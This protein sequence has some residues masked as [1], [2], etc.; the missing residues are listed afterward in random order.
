MIGQVI[1]LTG[2]INENSSFLCGNQHDGDI[3][4][5]LIGAAYKILRQALLK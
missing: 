1:A 2:G 3:P 4:L 5:A